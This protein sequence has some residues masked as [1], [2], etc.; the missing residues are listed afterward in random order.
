MQVLPF[1]IY[2]NLMELIDNAV[3]ATAHRANPVI[4]VRLETKPGQSPVGM[5]K[6]QATC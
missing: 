2:V 1:D 4:D 6:R 3:D 5:R